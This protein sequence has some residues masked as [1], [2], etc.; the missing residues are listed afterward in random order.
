MILA[1][2]PPAILSRSRDRR[3]PAVS[4]PSTKRIR[5]LLVDDHGVVRSGV[6]ALVAREADMD[7][8]GEAATFEEALGAFRSLRPD[9]VVTD[10]SLAAADGLDLIRTLRAESYATP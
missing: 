4:P 9:V 3:R 7:V 6:A 2:P 5:V 1:H 10:L 8:C